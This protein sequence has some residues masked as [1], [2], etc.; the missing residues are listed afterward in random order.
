MENCVLVSDEFLADG[1][2]IENWPPRLNVDAGFYSDRFGLL[3]FVEDEQK[4]CG[5]GRKERMNLILFLSLQMR[6]RTGLVPM[7]ARLFGFGLFPF[8]GFL[9]NSNRNNENENNKIK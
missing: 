6:L 3:G 1:L 8:F 5:L 7:N 9:L 2:C 4:S